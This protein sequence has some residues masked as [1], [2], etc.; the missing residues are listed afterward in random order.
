MPKQFLNINHKIF[1]KANYLNLSSRQLATV[2]GCSRSV[3]QKYMK[4]AKLKPSAEIIEQFRRNALKGRTL[5]SAEM[6]SYLINNYL[7]TPIKPMAKKLKISSGCVYSRMKQLKLKVPKEIVEKRKKIGQFKPGHEPFTKGKKRTEYATARGIEIM[8]KTQ[9]KKGHKPHN[10][11]EGT[12]HIVIRVDSK[13]KR[14]YKYIKIADG[15]WQLLH[16]VN[17]E[18]KNGPIPPGSVIRFRDGN[19]LNC[20]DINNL[21]CIAYAENCEMNVN[22]FNNY[23]DPLKKAI[24][25]K[26]K[27]L[28]TLKNE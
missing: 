3:V 5:F 8:Q 7:D 25:L 12:G 4:K 9:F 20:E 1:I 27:I 17:Y 26:N 19:T 2:L 22:E 23:P 10:T 14:P 21:E 28:K 13:S 6:D 11:K 15:D 24:K 18:K 16:R